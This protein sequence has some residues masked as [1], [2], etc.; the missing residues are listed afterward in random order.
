MVDIRTNLLKN[1]QTLSEKDYQRERL[2]LRYAVFGLVLVVVVVVAMS[3]WNLVLTR[4]LGGVEQSLTSANKEMQG[5]SQASAQ[6]IYLKS[7]LKLITSFLSDRSTARDALQKVLAVDVTGVHLAGVKFGEDNTL[8]VQYGAASTDSLTQLLSYFQT[9]TNYFTQVVG[10][11][12]S[13]AKEGDYQLSLILTLPV[14][15]KEVK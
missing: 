8:E 14:Q 2:M 13:R 6:Q 1:R 10:S 4:R 3:A 15:A 5:L 11:G 7:R 9:D 12:I